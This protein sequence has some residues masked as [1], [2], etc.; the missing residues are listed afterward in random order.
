MPK[1]KRQESE[2]LDKNTFDDNADTNAND[3]NDFLNLPSYA[4]PVLPASIST[5]G[6]QLSNL[7]KSSPIGRFISWN[8]LRQHLMGK[9]NGQRLTNVRL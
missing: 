7:K 9:R 4:K 1:L 5:R 3:A 2:L 8:Y 6:S